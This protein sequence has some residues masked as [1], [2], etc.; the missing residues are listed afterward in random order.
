MPEHPPQYHNA[1][2]RTVPTKGCRVGRGAGAG[3]PQTVTRSGR[4]MRGAVRGL[5]IGAVAEG[6]A[7]ATRGADHGA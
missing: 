6:A 4:L 1:Y 2:S 7:I 3:P 5:S